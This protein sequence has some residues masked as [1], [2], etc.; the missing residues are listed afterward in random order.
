MI[1]AILLRDNQMFQITGNSFVRSKSDL[2]LAGLETFT[3][4]TAATTIETL[5]FF[6]N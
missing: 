1:A 2:S 4:M 3:P 5:Q 6:W